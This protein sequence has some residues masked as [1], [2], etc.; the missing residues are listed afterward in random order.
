M[1][2]NRRHHN[3]DG[4]RQVQR[5]RTRVQVRHMARRLGVPYGSQQA[6]ESA[7]NIDA[8]DPDQPNAVGDPTSTRDKSSS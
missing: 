7:T 8:V 2:E 6:V 4:R 5:G 3:T 1:P